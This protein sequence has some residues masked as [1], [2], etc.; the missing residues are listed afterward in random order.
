MPLCSNPSPEAAAVASLPDA[1]TEPG[2]AAPALVCA[3]DFTGK[4]S[5][6][7]MT[8]VPLH[9]TWQISNASLSSDVVEMVI[10]SPSCMQVRLK[11]RVSFESLNAVRMLL[12]SSEM[13]NLQ[14]I[15]RMPSV[16]A[17][18]KRHACAISTC[19]ACRS[20]KR[21][22]H[23]Q[24]R[25]RTRK[26]RQPSAVQSSN[27]NIRSPRHRKTIALQCGLGWQS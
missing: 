2:C 20:T 5:L 19:I 27:T 14:R 4:K 11:S 16:C 6:T 25:S 24:N 12:V 3:H 17:T 9:T 15:K 7:V 21:L 13:S 10:S 8:A 22:K 23:K 1:R 26:K 18:L